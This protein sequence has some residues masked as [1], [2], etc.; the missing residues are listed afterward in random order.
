M[1]EFHQG[2]LLCGPDYTHERL[3]IDTGAPNMTGDGQT[4]MLGRLRGVRTQ[5]T[6]QTQQT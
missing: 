1:T 5:R 2:Y 4:A 3:V 6:P